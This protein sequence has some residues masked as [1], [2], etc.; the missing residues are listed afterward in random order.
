M[1]RNTARLKSILSVVGIETLDGVVLQTRIFPITSILWRESLHSVLRDRYR[2]VTCLSPRYD[3]SVITSLNAAAIGLFLFFVVL[4]WRFSILLAVLLA[5]IT[6]VIGL[7]SALLIF[8]GF[9]I[10]I[11]FLE[12]GIALLLLSITIAIDSVVGLKMAIVLLLLILCLLFL[13]LILALSDGPG[14]RT[15]FKD[16]LTIL[17]VGVSSALSTFVN[18][19]EWIGT[20]PSPRLGFKSL[21]SLYP[22]LTFTRQLRKEFVEIMEG[23]VKSGEIDVE[24]SP[25]TLA[26]EVREAYDNAGQLLSDGEGNLALVLAVIS[27]I[28]FLPEAV[29]PPDWILPPEWSGAVLSITLLV[30]VGLRQAALDVVLFQDAAESEGKARLAAMSGWNH[31][32]SNGAKIVQSLAIFKAVDSI[33]PRAFQYYIEWVIEE[34]LTEEGVDTFDVLRQWKVLMCLVIADRRDITPTEASQQLPFSTTFGES[35]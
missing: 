22:G 10:L 21:F 19:I 16:S 18:R 5:A 6:Y 1:L 34:S 26:R 30:A 23:Y 12:P 32:M 4:N 25:E 15:G 2:K 27:I 35:E 11:L 14:V 8:V 33:S 13:L 17:S 3:K 9:G 20:L 7:Q 29:S 31:H 24:K 28:P